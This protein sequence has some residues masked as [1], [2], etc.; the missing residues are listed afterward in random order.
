M[1]FVLISQLS[2]QENITLIR[3]A[4]IDR[5]DRNRSVAL[6]L[7]K[8]T[9]LPGTLDKLDG[10]TPALCSPALAHSLL[11]VH[12]KTCKV[13]HGEKMENQQSKCSN[14]GGITLAS[15]AKPIQYVILV[16]VL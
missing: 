15:S 3:I 11:L 12:K 10:I 8:V 6:V 5:Y 1:V 2:R 16:N 7:V 14:F 13:H 9:L 4:F